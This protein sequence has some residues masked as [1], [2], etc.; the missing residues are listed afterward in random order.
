ML[1]YSIL[2]DCPDSYFDLLQVFLTYLSINWPSSLDK[3]YV[4][5]NNNDISS[6][7]TV[8]FVKCGYNLNSIQRSKMALEIIKTKFVIIMDCDC[9]VSK[10]VDDNEIN[11]LIEYMSEKEI[12]YV[13]LWKSKNKEQKKC[14]TDFAKLYYCNPN[15]RYS[16]SLMA[17]IWTKKAYFD[18]VVNLNVDGWSVEKMWLD[19][20]ANQHSNYDSLFC[21]YDNDPLHILH[22]VSKGKWI[23]G[24]LKKV[25]KSG[26]ILKK[27]ICREKCSITETIKQNISIFCNNNFSS[28]TIRN[29]KKVVGPKKFVTNN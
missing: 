26:I 25:I 7:K 18:N 19:D 12:G 21:Y 29:L 16:K 17:N 5:T 3:L 28:K 20:S 22:G 1:D 10:I 13:K 24:S 6:Y 11:D 14:K 27:N 23:R 4:T 8:R 15:A 2:V 9:F